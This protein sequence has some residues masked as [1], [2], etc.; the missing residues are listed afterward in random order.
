MKSKY[1]AV[2]L[3]TLLSAC[4]LNQK[5]DSGA[6]PTNKAIFAY[7][8]SRQY[9]TDD[10][11]VGGL[12]EVLATPVVGLNTDSFKKSGIPTLNGACNAENDGVSVPLATLS[13]FQ[14]IG[15]FS[16]MGLTPNEAEPLKQSS[17]NNLVYFLNKQL[18]AGDYS[19]KVGGAGSPV[20]FTQALSV[21]GSSPQLILQSGA[22]GS[23]A[24]L[25]SPHVPAPTDADYTITIDRTQDL[26]VAYT[27]PEGTTYVRISFHSYAVGADGKYTD[28]AD[29]TCYT[30]PENTIIGIAQAAVASF[31][32]TDNG[33]ITFDFVKTVFGGAVGRVQETMVD[34]MVRQIH[35]L[36]PVT[37]ADGT[38]KLVHLGVLKFQ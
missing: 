5:R 25:P 32:A 10:A 27:P 17:S 34:S 23:A 29:M 9:M 14:E 4:N 30:S 26:Y 35:G 31:D 21:P 19:F 11:D 16:L 1:F 24:K 28:S 18:P 3:I 22:N 7:F 38:Q 8:T 15:T 13:R 37:Q 36:V 12:S 33:R 6:S 20:D 2:A